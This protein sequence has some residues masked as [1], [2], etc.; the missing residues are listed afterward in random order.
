MSFIDVDDVPDWEIIEMADALARSD[1]Q[2]S[3]LL[4]SMLCPEGAVAYAAAEARACRERAAERDA[5][6]LACLQMREI[7]K[8]RAEL[9][10]A[11]EAAARVREQV[12]DLDQARAEISRL[13]ASCKDAQASLDRDKASL[14]RDKAMLEGA[15]R[16]V[17]EKATRLAD[18]EAAFDRKRKRAELEDLEDDGLLTCTICIEKERDQALPCGH[19]LCK[20]CVRKLTRTVVARGHRRAHVTANEF[21]RCPTCKQEHKNPK[22]LKIFMN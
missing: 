15:R 13:M 7:A 10:G 19:V 6:A 18:D 20:D 14:D 8:L 12:G 16:M 2:D 1:G 4:L 17:D 9:V 21:V 11:R 22:L 5:E 3:A